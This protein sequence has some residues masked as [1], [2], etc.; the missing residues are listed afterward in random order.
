MGFSLFSVGFVQIEQKMLKLAK[1]QQISR[2]EPVEW[3]FADGS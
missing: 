1:K 3:Q 2:A